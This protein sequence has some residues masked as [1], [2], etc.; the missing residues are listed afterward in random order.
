MSV[1]DAGSDRAP[2]SDPDNGWDLVEFDAGWLILEHATID[3]MGAGSR[4]VERESGR[5]ML[6][7]S[8]IPPGRILEEYDQVAA[9]GSPVDLRPGTLRERQ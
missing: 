7:P 8:F 2:A 3:L 4:V 1:M 5:V 9:H 6:F